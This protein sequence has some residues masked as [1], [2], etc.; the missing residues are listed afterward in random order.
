MGL[1]RPGQG[2]SRGSSRGSGR[3][4]GLHEPPLKRSLGGDRP[5]GSLLEKLDSNHA[6]SPG[7]VLLTQPHRCLHRV[8]GDGLTG[9]AVM[10]I[11]RDAI[12]APVTKP[13][14]QSTNGGR[15]Q[16]Q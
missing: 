8:R 2:D 4:A 6:R 15:G 16:V 13:L 7:G 10:I 12:D 5:F 1:G 3:Q 11:R 9:G 14:E